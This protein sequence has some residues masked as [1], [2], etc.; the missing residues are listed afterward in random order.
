MR[1]EFDFQMDEKTLG[2]F[3]M[4]HN[5]G[6]ISGFLWPVLGAFAIVIAVVS[7]SATPILYRLVYALFGL[8]FI[9]YIPWD[10]KRKAKKQV[11]TNPYYAQPI[12]YVIDEEGVTTT[13]GDQTATVQWE[14]F[15]KL[16]ITKKSMF[17]YMRNKNACVFSND[18]F[19]KDLDAAYDFIK[20]K[21][22]HK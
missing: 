3:Y 20:S 8:M 9:F 5:M 10:L 22:E 21:V 18:V 11:K 14:N 17:L 7:G 1:Y 13:Q 19:G 12:H 6:G 15:S 2:D 16:K 4:S